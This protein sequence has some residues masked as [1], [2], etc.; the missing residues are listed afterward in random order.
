MIAVAAAVCGAGLLARGAFRS[1]APKAPPAPVGPVTVG[2]Y[3]EGAPLANRWVVF[4]DGSGSVLSRT[5]SGRDGRASGAV[6]A[7]GAVTV[8]HGESLR[9]LVTFLDVE[10][11]DEITIGEKDEEETVAEVV[12]Q[13]QVRIP[14]PLPGAGR[15]VV[16]LGVGDTAVVPGQPVTLSVLRRFLGPDG[17]FRVLAEALADDGAPLAY[18][19]EWATWDDAKTKANGTVE[20]SL[21]AWRR[22]WR[23]FDLAVTGAPPGARTVEGKLSIFSKDEDRFDRSPRRAELDGGAASLGFPVP[24]PLGAE[25]QTRLEVAF[26][27]APD[28]LV[29]L[30]RDESLASTTRLDLGTALLPR[31]SAAALES[32]DSPARPAIRFTTAGA[33][34]TAADAVVVRA[35]WPATR[36]HVWTVVMPPPRDRAAVRVQL[37]A[38]PPE[39]ASWQPDGRPATV[40]AAV[41][42]ASFYEGYADVKKKGILLVTEPPEDERGHSLLRYAVTGDLTF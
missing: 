29:L 28:R 42:E 30:R 22:D 12:G 2:V 10:P 40:G 32:T 7:G 13:V 35:S 41:V 16:S 11:G 19:F 9:H 3:D 20:A 36:E 39:L 24:P 23:T 21:R 31:V 5:M 27:D 15:Y 25:A 8:A 33:G 4:H 18:A 34:S 6:P 14:G 26:G 37:P 1:T 17:K 38:L